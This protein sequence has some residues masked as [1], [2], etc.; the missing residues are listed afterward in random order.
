MWPACRISST[1]RSFL[2]VMAIAGSGL[3]IDLRCRDGIEDRLLN[4][5]DIEVPVDRGHQAAAPIEVEQWFG[6][7]VIKLE[8]LANGIRH[9]VRALHQ[10]ATALIADARLAGRLEGEVVGRAAARA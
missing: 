7:V 5:F 10:L 2:I 1:S 4:S 3:L 9:I 8:A 6:Q